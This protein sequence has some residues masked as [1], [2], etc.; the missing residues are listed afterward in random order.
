MGLGLE[1]G[2]FDRPT[3]PGVVGMCSCLRV[4]ISTFAFQKEASRLSS[5]SAEINILKLH[6]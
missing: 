3:A 5:D 6:M 4:P 1:H 2:P